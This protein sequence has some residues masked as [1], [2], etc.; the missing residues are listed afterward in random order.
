MNVFVKFFAALRYREAIKK[1]NMAHELNGHRYYVLPADETSLKLIVMDRYNFRK[2]KNKKYINQDARVFHLINESFYFT[3][4]ANG[5]GYLSAYD[6]V[7]KAEMYYKWV[8]ACRK[9]KKLY[10]KKKS[11]L[12]RWLHRAKAKS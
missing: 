6:Q 4:Y 10:G 9:R 2:L 12:R 3:P 5:D 11:V 8:D 1:A 7:R